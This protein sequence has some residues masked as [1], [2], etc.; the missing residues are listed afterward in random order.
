MMDTIEGNDSLSINDGDRISDA[1][2][3]FLDEKKKKSNSIVTYRQYSSTLRLA[4]KHLQKNDLDFFSSLQATPEEKKQHIQIVA[5]SLLNYVGVQ[6]ATQQFRITVL[7]TF[8]SNKKVQALCGKENPIP[9]VKKSF[10][11]KKKVIVEKHDVAKIIINT[12]SLQEL[13]DVVLLLLFLESELNATD[14]SRL[15][16]KDIDIDQHSRIVIRGIVFHEITSQLVL[17]YIFQ[18][19]GKEFDEERSLLQSFIS[20]TFHDGISSQGITGILKKLVGATSPAMET[21]KLKKMLDTIEL[22]DE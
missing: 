7:N 11:N 19:F 2:K 1:I 21:T 14:L 20:K 3:I 4:R 15:K 12:H 13:R 22:G 10:P 9:L 5:T 8:Y 17:R 6:H 16:L 18:Y